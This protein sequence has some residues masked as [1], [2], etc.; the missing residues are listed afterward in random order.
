MS[1]KARN[2]ARNHEEMRIS[3]EL[4]SYLPVVDDELLAEKISQ[5]EIAALDEFYFAIF[6]VEYF[7]MDAARLVYQLGRKNKLENAHSK[8]NVDEFSFIAL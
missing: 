4:G 7:E 8:V 3:L 1:I 5:E 6:D 2:C